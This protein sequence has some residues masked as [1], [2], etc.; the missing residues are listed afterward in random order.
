M[1]ND[2]IKGEMRLQSPYEQGALHVDVL[3]V[4]CVMK[5]CAK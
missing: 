5:M 4:F 3:F 1:S 2:S